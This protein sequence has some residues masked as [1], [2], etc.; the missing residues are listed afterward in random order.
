M[1]AARLHEEAR[2][3]E[4]VEAAAPIAGPGEAL[5]AVRAC[6]ICAS[7]LHALDGTIATAFRP[8][9][10]GHEAAG[11][12]VGLGPPAAAGSAPGP[13]RVGDR[14]AL[15]PIVACG[16]C[17]ACGRGQPQLCA[18]RTLIGFHR[19]GAFA[20]LVAVPQSCL[21]LLP[22]GLAF[23][24]AALVEPA[25]TAFHALTAVASVRVGDAVAVVGAGGLG[26]HAIQ[27]ARLAGAAEVIAVDIADVALERARTL[28]ATHV[29]DA[30]AGDPVHAIRAVVPGGVDVAVECVGRR[31][32]CLWAARAL[33]PG[34]TAAIIG[35]GSD[36]VELPPATVLTSKEIGVRGSFGYTPAELE[37]VADLIAT[38]RLDVRAAISATYA[39]ADAA[40]AIEAVRERRGNPVRVLLLPS[41][42]TPPRVI[43]IS[44]RSAPIEPRGSSGRS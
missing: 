31:E 1:L 5:V 37:T 4:V 40:A 34:G 21:V 24:E 32:T 15:N 29:V 42:T 39:L 9:T 43:A 38:R 10:L 2:S 25:A 19:D 26:V 17:R 18:Q 22:D 35:V 6:G 36:A 28:G 44:E 7:D 11:E 13:F 27:V 20:E 3:L 23:D 33:R 30:R 8:I 12:V 16:A 41:A 14:V